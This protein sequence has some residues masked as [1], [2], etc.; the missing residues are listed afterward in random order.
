[1]PSMGRTA[2]RPEMHQTPLAQQG[3]E[4]SAG[5]RARTDGKSA[6]YELVRRTEHKPIWHRRCVAAQAR[7][8]D[9]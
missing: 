6:A 2:D 7:S 3:A 4:G 9:L 5:E 8:L 1:M